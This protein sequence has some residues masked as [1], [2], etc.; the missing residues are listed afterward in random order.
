M[1]TTSTSGANFMTQPFGFGNRDLRFMHPTPAVIAKSGLWAR[2]E[3]D[4]MVRDM[5][6]TIGKEAI[7]RRLRGSRIF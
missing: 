5:L 7:G 2:R 4:P 3:A 1:A 6:F